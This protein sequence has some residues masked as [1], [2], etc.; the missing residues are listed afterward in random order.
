M[1]NL[2]LQPKYRCGY[3]VAGIT[4]SAIYLVVI[5]MGIVMNWGQIVFFDGE[6]TYELILIAAFILGFI[7]ASRS[8]LWGGVVLIIVSIATVLYTYLFSKNGLLFML[9][10]LLAGVFM[11]F[12]WICGQRGGRMC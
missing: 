2:L 9:P 3:L 10:L 7:M 4:I 1:L 6:T 12:S 11:V 8:P 5:T